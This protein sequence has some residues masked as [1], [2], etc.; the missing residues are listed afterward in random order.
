MICATVFATLE[1]L[2]FRGAVGFAAHQGFPFH[3]YWYTDLIHN[4]E[5]ANG[6]IWSGLVLDVVSWLFAIVLLGWCV[7]YI[8]RRYCS[9]DE[10][11]SA[12]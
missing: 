3:W 8:A 7:E 4:N 12:A 10:S 9:N 11:K 2:R 5:P 1:M 6:Y